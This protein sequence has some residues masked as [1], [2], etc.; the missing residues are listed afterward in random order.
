[1]RNS[2]FFCAV[3]A[4]FSVSCVFDFEKKIKGNGEVT[5]EERPVSSFDKIR[6]DGVFKVFLSQGN[7]EKVE[8][9]I[10]GNLQS[11]VN[12][13]NTGSVLNLDIEKGI[14]WSKTTKNNVY[15]TLKNIHELHI[16]GVCS[17]ATH[18]FLNQDE[19]QLFINGVSNSF[20][21]LN[22][23]Q[24]SVR[25]NGV[26]SVELVG[27]TLR[28]IAVKDGVG[29][30]NASD[31]HANVVDIRNSGV[32]NAHTYASEELY[33]R[34]SGIGSIYYSGDAIIKL[35]ESDGIGKIHKK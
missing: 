25:M 7:T 12:V 32:G 18:T 11:F 28:F 34:N 4:L 10:D 21:E 22:C 29:S 6:L 26:E 23:D 2:L 8:V 13:Y 20:L 9:E 31:L 3:I 17:V 35:I 16:E 19:L 33:M 30:L 1:M 5:I 14:H 27:E 15:I 24:L